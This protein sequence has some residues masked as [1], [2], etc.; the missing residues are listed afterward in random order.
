LSGH[1]DGRSA[2]EKSVILERMIKCNHP[3]FGDDNKAKLEGLFTF[4]L[5]HLHDCASGGDAW[6]IIF[7]KFWAIFRLS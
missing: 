3:Q 2:D 1:F 7:G 4:V 6:A 5:Q